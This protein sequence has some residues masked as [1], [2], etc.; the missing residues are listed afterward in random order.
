MRA[1][2]G[3]G[4]GVGKHVC[5]PLNDRHLSVSSKADSREERKGEREEEY[6]EQARVASIEFDMKIA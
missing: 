4:G 6:E 2:C 1:V 3:E 5:L